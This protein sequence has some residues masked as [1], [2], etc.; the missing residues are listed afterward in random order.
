MPYVVRH[1]SGRSPFWYAVYRD[2]TGRRIKKST[3]LTSKSKAL[4]MAHTLQ[5]A[6]REAR[7]H[8]LTEA[9]VRELLA[10]VMEHTSGVVLQT[11]S[12]AKWL[13]HCVGQKKKSRADKT[14]LRYEQVAR[15]FAELLGP[16][17]D[18]NVAAVTAR[19]IADFRDRREAQGLS[20]AT[21]NGDVAIL[22][23]VFNAALRQGHISVNPCLAIEPVKDKVKAKKRTFAPQQV[24]ALMDVADGDW[25]GLMLTLWDTGQRLGDCA[26]LQ[27]RQIDLDSPIKTIRFHQAKTDKEVV[28]VIHEQ[29]EEFLT[30]LQKQRRIVPLERE[31]D[32]AY[33]FPSL[34]QRNISPLSKYFRGL[35]ARAGIQQRIIR[36]AKT[37]GRNVNAYSC[38]S[39]RHSFNSILDNNGVPV[40]RRMALTGHGSVEMNRRYANT[41][42]RVF[43]DIIALIPRV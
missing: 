23:S 34:A 38:H 18:N 33:V 27:W 8:R 28:V 6:V 15:E 29:L 30:T 43:K 17:A 39:F 24:R 3:K 42:L 22:S 9:R 25:P 36:Q 40:E 12:V 16:R 4:E 1:A 5:R 20:P 19:D 26:N 31:D 35:L 2:E 37:G 11:F 41:E 14:A 7:Q 10:E 13:A 32:A 21:L